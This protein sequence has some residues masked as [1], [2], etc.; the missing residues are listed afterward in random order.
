M[1]ETKKQNYLKGAAILAA[2]GIIVKVITAVFKIPL[3]NLL[4]DKGSGHFQVAFNLYTLLLTISTAGIPVALSRLVSAAT[5]TG[6]VSLARRYFSVA[7]PVFTLIG[8]T[9][10]ALMLSFAENL[11]VFMEDEKAAFGIRTLAPAILFSCVISVYRGYT[12]GHHNMVPTAVS[13]LFESLS[14]LIFGL[15]IAW[16]LVQRGY[17]SSIASAGAYFGSIIGLGLAI[18]YLIVSKIK[19]D[20]RV[21]APRLAPP[22][23]QTLPGR[24]SIFAQ[25]LKVSIP[26]TLGSAILNIMTFADT[27]VVISQLKNAVHFS[28]DEAMALYG[29]YSKGSTF[30]TLPAALTG[31]IAVSIVPAIAAAVASGRRIEAKEIMGSSMKL[32]NLLAMPAGIGMCILSYPIFRVIFWDSNPIGAT[33]LS[34]FGIA[35]Y[36]VC[37][38]LLSTALLQANGYERIPF[39]TCTVGGLLQLG[40]DWYLTGQ[41]EINI[42]G[43]PFGTLAC[44]G[45]ITILNMIFIALKVKDCPDFAKAFVK[46][47]LCTAAMAVGAWV[48][49]ELLYKAGSGVLGSGRFAL[50]VYLAGA[51]IAS[52][53]I[54]GILIIATKTVTRDDL[55]LI[56]RGEKIANL[57]KIK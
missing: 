45:S 57:L 21:H 43:S 41:P 3:Y 12:Q 5:S 40:L 36:F 28:P 53:V 30:M 23:K 33:L 27:K 35:A 13:Q 44:Y 49:Y 24:R 18:P 38:Q 6:R 25:I 56:P 37:M 10:M 4:G 39:V 26:I 48:I 2:T 16:V 55:K 11:A 50:A 7:L 54:Y 22:A 52:V 46:P 15:L 8:L 34:T 19:N 20:R 1:S 9:L 51:I 32:T 14:K 17:D 42:L 29:V 47:A 31:P